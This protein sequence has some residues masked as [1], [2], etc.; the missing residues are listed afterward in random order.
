M[1]NRFAAV[2]SAAVVRILLLTGTVSAYAQSTSTSSLPFVS[3]A[4]ASFDQPWAVAFLPENQAL[5]TERSGRL[6][7]VDLATGNSQAV[8]GVPEVEYGGQGGLGDVVL[9]PQFAQNRWVYWSYAEVGERSSAGAAI[10]RGRLEVTEKGP[11]LHD[12]SVI[13]RQVPKVSGRGHYAHR[14]LFD[15]DDLLWVS[16]G[17][18]Q[19][20]DPAQDL[21]S[22]LGK[23]L[24]LTDEGAAVEGNPFF[25]Q[26]GVAAQVWSLGHRN[27]LG[28]A[29]DAQ[30]QLWEVEMGPRGGDELNRIERG[31]NYGYPIV[32]N[33]D[34]YSGRTI[35]DHDTRPEFKA[36][37]I[38]WTPVIS[39]SSMVVYQGDDFP[40]WRGNAL[41]SG[42]SSQSLVRVELKATTAREVERFDMGRRIRAVAQAPDGALWVLEDGKKGRLL[43]LTPS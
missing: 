18:R 23:V 40:D 12:V 19:Q 29:F 20:F 28:I 34:H 11:S 7:W 21:Q 24:R 2:C 9:H 8:A 4:V 22:N 37:L 30:G 6:K 14:L 39:P 17:D 41:I 3:Q 5:V 35:P 33:G 26:G 31:S 32:S 38:T 43:R 27:P 42:L 36:P 25:K 1:K 10:A 13:W 15:R 16:S